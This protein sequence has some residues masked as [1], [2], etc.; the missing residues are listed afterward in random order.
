MGFYELLFTDIMRG[1]AEAQ[2]TIDDFLSEY[3]DKHR[4]FG[5]GV[6]HGIIN[7]FVIAFPFVS[8]SLIVEGKS[9]KQLWYPFSYWL[10][11]SIVIGGLI[12]QF[13]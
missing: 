12:S 1:N 11:T 7:A 13:V 10:I 4:H 6:F 3:G 8:V 2:T 9:I 5:H